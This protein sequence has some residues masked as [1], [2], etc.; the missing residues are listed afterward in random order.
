[1]VYSG[2][3]GFSS[4]PVIANQTASSGGNARIVNGRVEVQQADGTWLAA[5]GGTSNSQYITGNGIP[6]VSPAIPADDAVYESLDLNIF[7]RWDTD[8]RL[9]RSTGQVKELLVLAS[10]PAS[11]WTR[12]P[13]ATVLTSID[14]WLLFRADG[15]ALTTIDYRR[16]TDGWPELHSLNAYSNLQIRAFGESVCTPTS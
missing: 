6:T 14:E 11:T 16:A 12:M 10:L 9:W 5:S 1:M 7:Y 4:A 8:T 2:G 3:S 13:T 15:Q